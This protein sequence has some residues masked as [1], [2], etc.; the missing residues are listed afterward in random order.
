MLAEPST[1]RPTSTPAARYFLTGAIPD[2]RRMLELGQWATP[3]PAAGE[4]A[5]L[6][7]AHVHRVGEP[8]VA[9][10]PAEPVHPLDRAH[11]EALERVALLVEGLREVGVEAH[12]PRAGERGGLAQEVGAHGER[13]A[14]REDD[15]GHRPRQGS[16]KRSMTR[17]E[18]SRMKA[19]S[20]TASSGGQAPLRAAD[21]HRPAAR[22]EADADLARRLDLHVHRVAAP[23]EVR[24]VEDGRAAREQ[25]LGEADQRAQAGRLRVDAG[26]RRVLR[27]EPVEEAGVLGGGE[28]AGQRLVEVV[29][30]VDEAGQDD[31]ARE[32]EHHVGGRRQ[33]AVG[34]TWRTKPSTA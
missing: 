14:R 7:V 28:G 31:L 1:A 21:G 25:Q 10:D 8:D 12:A 15:A 20:S 4:A 23:E 5:D 18:S 27:G 9:R 34:P 32:V 24:V 11:P 19:S 30:R 3:Q 13:R 2:A 6:G 33:L 29:V 16:W 22:V 26:P 17:S